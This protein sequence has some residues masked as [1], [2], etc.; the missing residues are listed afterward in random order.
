MFRAWI[1][2]STLL[3]TTAGSQTKMSPWRVGEIIW[4]GKSPGTIP[5]AKPGKINPPRQPGFANVQYQPGKSNRAVDVASNMMAPP[6][7]FLAGAAIRAAMRGR[8]R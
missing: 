7:V 6:I 5:H 4:F 3:M 1:F 2:A 8:S